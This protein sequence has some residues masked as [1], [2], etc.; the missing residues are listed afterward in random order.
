MLEKT[1][2][3]RIASRQPILSTSRPSGGDAAEAVI[4]NAAVSP[5]SPMA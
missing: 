1:A 2:L 3:T 5:P 4:Q